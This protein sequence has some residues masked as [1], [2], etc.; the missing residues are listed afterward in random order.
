MH[1]PTL[2]FVSAVATVSAKTININVGQ[3][4]LVFEPNITKA[5]KGDIVQ[6]TFFKGNHNVVEG[7]Y[8]MPCQTGSG[9]K[10]YSG[11]FPQVGSDG[12]AVSGIPLYTCNNE[13]PML[14]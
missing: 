3:G 1:L 14:L 4:G 11:F 9:N 7:E 5:D 10:F 13:Y 2:F 6:F 12:M 8:D